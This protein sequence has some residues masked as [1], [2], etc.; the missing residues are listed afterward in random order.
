ME[1]PIRSKQLAR[2]DLGS[3]AAWP[4]YWWGAYFFGVSDPGWFAMFST[5]KSE[6]EMLGTAQPV[7]SNESNNSEFHYAHPSCRLLTRS[8]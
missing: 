5:A 1:G 3:S 2:P 6:L 4:F 8:E 7:S